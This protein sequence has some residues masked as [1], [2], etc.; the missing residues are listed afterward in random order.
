M[1]N[2]TLLA[3]MLLFSISSYSQTICLTGSSVKVLKPYGQS[4][5]NGSKMAIEELGL[6]GK[7]SIKKFFY[8]KSPL[9]ARKAAKE[10]LKA[11]CSVIFGFTNKNDLLSVKNI[12]KDKVLVISMYG[13]IHRKSMPK[14]IITMQPSPQYLTDNLFRY[15]DS[16]KINIKRPLIITSIDKTSFLDYKESFKNNFL[17]RGGKSYEIDILEKRFNEEKFQKEVKQ[18]MGKYDSLVLLNLSLISA[19][20]TDYLRKEGVLVLGT[21]NFGTS[22]GSG[23]YRAIKNKDID[24]IFARQNSLKDKSKE[25]Q[26]FKNK[27]SLKFKTQPYVIS[28]MVYD[29]V[30]YVF[31]NYKGKASRLSLIETTSGNEHRG[32]TGVHFKRELKVSHTKWAIMG[33]SNDGYSLMKSG[34]IK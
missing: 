30:K 1:T 28:M 8:E 20:M 3:L 4:F 13:E 6:S 15:I 14:N 18:F 19:K 7:V 34:E 27:Y 9:E 25:V 12:L 33:I 32:I 2:I 26:R 16:E 31:S 17:N 22:S 24:V 5:I 10:M 21:K 23:Y 11:D 29:A